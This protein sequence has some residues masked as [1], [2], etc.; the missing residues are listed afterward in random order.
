MDTGPAT[1]VLYTVGG[2][3]FK[4]AVAVVKLVKKSLSNSYE[5]DNNGLESM[6]VSMTMFINHVVIR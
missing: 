1:F 5:Y 6:S 4:C 3:L 2:R